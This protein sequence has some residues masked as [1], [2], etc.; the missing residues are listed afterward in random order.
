[1]NP[2]AIV[3]RKD[4]P[5]VALHNP[6]VW[7][8][9]WIDPQF[10][11]V[12]DALGGS[13]YDR[14]RELLLTVGAIADIGFYEDGRDPQGQAWWRFHLVN[15]STCVL[16][17]QQWHPNNPAGGSAYFAVHPNGR[18]ICGTYL[19]KPAQGSRPMHPQTAVRTAGQPWVT[20]ALKWFPP[21]DVSSPLYAM[22]NPHMSQAIEPATYVNGR[23]VAVCGWDWLEIGR[24]RQ[25][26]RAQGGTRDGGWLVRTK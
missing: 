26:V 15:Q 4:E 21:Q 16:W 5:W 23:L 11:G 12:R 19:T 18:D 3:P 25:Y 9:V 7:L 6:T 24:W 13:M 8:P 2:V 22:R 1:M 10:R 14:R 17:S 20:Q